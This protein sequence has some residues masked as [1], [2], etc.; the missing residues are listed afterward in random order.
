MSKAQIRLGLVGV[1]KIAR[2]SHIPAIAENPRF[3]L[4]GTASRHGDAPDVPAYPDLDSLIAA[5]LG[6]DAIVLCTPPSVR[7]ALAHRALATG[8][9]VFL[10]KP[11]AVA[12]SQIAHLHTTAAQAGRS[13]FASWHSRE[14]AAVDA[15][16]AWLAPRR[17]DAV[18]VIWREDVRQWHPGQDWL[19]AAG[20]FGVFDP[21]I[22][23]LSILTRILPAALALESAELHIPANRAAPMRADLTLSHAGAPIVRCDLDILHQGHQQWDIEVE[24]DAGRLVL[25]AGG[26][27]L[28]V[29]GSPQPLAPNREYP[30]LYDRFAQLVDTGQSD[31]DTMPLMLVADAMMLGAVCSIAPFEF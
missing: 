4:V 26:H 10:E 8:H 30:R 3:A 16:A 17:I 20:G 11:P 24:T 18:R 19:L 5:D 27:A 15:A 12:L 9:H 22:N 1:G 7:T 23:A 25:A 28:T 6:L 29:A 2:D 13:L 31:V 21:A 14:S